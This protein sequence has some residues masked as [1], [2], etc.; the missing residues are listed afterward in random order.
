MIASDLRV[1][2]GLAAHFSIRVGGKPRIGSGRLV[3]P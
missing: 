1:F 3:T 2:L